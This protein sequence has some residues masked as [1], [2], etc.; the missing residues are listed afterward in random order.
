MDRVCRSRAAPRLK[1]WATS[2]ENLSSYQVWLKPSCSSVASWS[3]EILD[4][5]SIGIIVS[6]QRTIKTLIRLHGSAGGP[7]S[8]L[9]AYSIKQVFLWRGSLIMF[10]SVTKL[11][12]PKQRK[13]ACITAMNWAMSWENRFLPYANNKGADQPAHPRSLISAFGFAA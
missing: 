11:Y 10:A 13:V 12:L 7:V 1:K 5:A 4:I 9:F 8:L 3:L 2:R 6:K